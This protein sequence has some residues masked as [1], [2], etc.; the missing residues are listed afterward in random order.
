M[1]LYKLQ[2]FYQRD[3]NQ[4]KSEP[5]QLRIHAGGG[6]YL[7]GVVLRQSPPRDALRSA[8]ECLRRD[9]MRN[10]E[11]IRETRNAIKQTDT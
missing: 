11:Q 8:L 2:L 1:D 10:D 4:N 7:G 9:A 6:V 3:Q 5:N